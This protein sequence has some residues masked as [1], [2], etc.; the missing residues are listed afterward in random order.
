VGQEKAV[1]CTM[2][3]TQY[4]AKQVMAVGQEKTADCTMHATLSERSGSH[5]KKQ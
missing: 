4:Q 1:D 3:A 2:L 5:E